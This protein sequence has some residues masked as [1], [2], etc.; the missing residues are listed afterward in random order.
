MKYVI[1]YAYDVPHYADFCVEAPNKKIALQMA[2]EAFRLGRFKDVNCQPDDTHA[3]ER[4][5]VQS[6]AAKY[7][8]NLERL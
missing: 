4:I 6:R 5:F 1:S 3:N 2:H 8:D 7:D